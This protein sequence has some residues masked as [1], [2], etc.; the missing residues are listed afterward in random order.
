MNLGPVTVEG[1]LHLVYHVMH[2]LGEARRVAHYGL[3]G[4]RHS[5]SVTM[6][7]RKRVAH[8]RSR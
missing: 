4:L 1:R 7:L 6:E 3:D 8:E 2:D 5:A